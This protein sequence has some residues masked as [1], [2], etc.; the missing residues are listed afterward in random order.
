[1][2]AVGRSRV[3]GGGG[4]GWKVRCCGRS[5]IQKGC[6][7]RRSKERAPSGGVGL[8]VEKNDRVWEKNDRV[9]EKIAISGNKRRKC[10]KN[11]FHH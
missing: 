1:M 5:Y 2:G 3:G 9:W 7:Y 6:M 10:G 8:V 4:P 11:K